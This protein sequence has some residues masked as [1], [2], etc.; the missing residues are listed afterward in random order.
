MEGWIDRWTDGLVNSSV[1]LMV[2]VSTYSKSI[3]R[4]QHVEKRRIWGTVTARH[5]ETNQTLQIQ[6]IIFFTVAKT[7][8]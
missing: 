6:E 3:E 2:D 1:F 8:V 5:Q 4:S 7:L